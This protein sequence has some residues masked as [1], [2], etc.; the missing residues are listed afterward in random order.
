MTETNKPPGGLVTIC[1]PTYNRAHMVGQAIEAVLGQTYSNLELIIV[2]DGSKDDTRKVLDDYA[3]RDPRIRVIDKENEGIPDTVNRGWRE[4]RGEYVTWTSDDNLYHPTTLE[5]M[6]NELR[7]HPNVGL[8]YTD[9]RNIDADGNVLGERQGQDPQVLE[10]DCPI[11][12]CLLFRSSVF[13]RVG[14]FRKQW[15]RCHDF[16]FYRRVSRQFPVRRVPQVLYDYR[17]HE[18][19]MSGDFHALRTEVAR[20]IVSDLGAGQSAAEVWAECWHHLGRKA[21]REG[22]RWRAT[23]YFLRAGLRAPRHLGTFSDTL[24]KSVYASLPSL[25]QQ[26]WRAC[27]AVWAK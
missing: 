23:G 24:W 27:K 22:R 1:M 8:V 11:M 18:A 14:M 9:C 5:V 12:G 2:N 20:V 17:V 19:S 26:Q 10:Y 3:R 15:P 25:V 13:E 6:V 7:E 16:D 4:A 21:L